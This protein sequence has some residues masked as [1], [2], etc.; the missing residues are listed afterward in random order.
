MKRDLY[1]KLLFWKDDPDRKPLII[2]GA[3]QVGKSYLV[4]E[5][6][7]TEFENCIILNCD[8]DPRIA[9]IFAHGFRVDRILSDIEILS[10]QKIVPGQTLLFIDEIGEAPKALAALKYFCEDMPS[11]H[12]IVAGS[13]LGLAI[14]QGV[15]FPVGKVNELVL[16]PLTFAEF[17]R[18]RSGDQAYERLMYHPINE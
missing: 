16:Y 13:L 17:L 11:L 18:A 6:G 7:N 1:K 9:E 15:S 3:R 5:F 12:V 10:G 2:Q 4:S 14:H 8:K